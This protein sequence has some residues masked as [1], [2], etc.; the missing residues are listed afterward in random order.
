MLQECDG[1]TVKRH[2]HQLAH[3][4]V[5]VLDHKIY[6]ER[7]LKTKSVHCEVCGSKSREAKMLLCD[8]CQKGYHID[9]LDE[10]LNEVP[11]TKWICGEHKVKL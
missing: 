11:Q 5:P 3:C 4:S 10:P 6:L 1:A 2:F 7:Y 8:V 9:C